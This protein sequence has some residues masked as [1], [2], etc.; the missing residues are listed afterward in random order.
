MMRI[1]AVGMS[2]GLL[3]AMSSADEQQIMQTAYA[4]FEREA[5]RMERLSQDLDVAARNLVRLACAAEAKVV[6]EMAAG[7][8]PPRRADQDR[9]RLTAYRS[10]I[11][12]AMRRLL[13]ARAARLK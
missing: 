10:L 6:M 11:D 4:C 7:M 9:L 12:S 3:V 1:A 13:D 8:A 2:W 5:P